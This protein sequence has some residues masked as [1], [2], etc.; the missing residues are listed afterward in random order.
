MKR[1]QV[2]MG[3]PAILAAGMLGAWPASQAAQGPVI[4]F[5]QSASLTGSQASYG[6]DIRDGIN[7][8]FAAASAV[9]GSP[10]FE[11][12]TLDDGGTKD[13]CIQNVGTLIEGGVTGIVGLTSGIA[14]EACVAMANKEQLALLGTASG[15]MGL[16]TGAAAGVF[17]T[18]AG[19]DLEYK[20]MANYIKEFG[21]RRIGYVYLKDTSPANLAVMTQSL[22]AVQITPTVSIAI[23][24]AG[25]NFEDVAASLMAA[26]V[27]IVLISANAGPVATIIDHMSN[28]KYPGLFYASSYA[29]QG[30][31]DTLTAKKQSC[32]M[33]MVV[34]RPNSGVANV[35]NKAKADFAALGGDV[36][37]GITTMEGYIAGRTAVEAARAA[38]KVSGGERVSRARL[39]ESIA[40]L[41]TD[42]GGYRVE[43]GPGVSQGSQYV[44]LIAIDRYGRLVG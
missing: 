36:K 16:R 1:R 28:A 11:L 21:M 20:R 9:P 17:H 27:D 40:G 43:F 38:L 23:E 5:G 25:T 4:R 7:A 3:S 18:R 44:D 34:P 22:N 15:N 13:R 14:A 26:K 31:M 37:L 33:S 19:Y 42:L 24:R 41:R 12:V 32:I 30:L 29:G 35:V 2:V 39:K 6:R 8:A 10:R